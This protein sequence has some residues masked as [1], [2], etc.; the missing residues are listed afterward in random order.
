VLKP[1]R[2]LALAL[3]TGALLGAAAAPASAGSASDWIKTGRS[4]MPL[5]YYQGVTHD[6][7][8]NVYFDGV[9]TGLYRTDTKLR[10]EAQNVDVIDP[11]VKQSVGFNHIGDITWDKAEGGRIVLPLEC[12]DASKTPSNTCGIGGFGVADP[13]T[14]AWEYWVKL[15]PADIPKAMWAETSPDGRLIWTSSGQDLLA[16]NAADVSRADA[17]PASNDGPAIR[18]ARRVVGAVPAHGITGAVFVGPRLFLAGQDG[19]RFQVSSVDLTSGR[20]R[21]EIVETI[22]GESEGLDTFRGLG[23]SF[24]W[25]VMPFPQGANPPS[26]ERDKGS[27]L[28][29]KARPTALELVVTP[30]RAGAGRRTRFGFR[31]TDDNGDPVKGA[32]VKF[33]HER[34][35]T[36]ARGR[37]TIT[38]TLRAPGRYTAVAAKRGLKTARAVVR[39]SR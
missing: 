27:L 39:S 34:A 8:G 5:N 31:V 32:T 17:Q 11:G 7:R 9:F 12:Y 20:A 35:R 37:A 14:L 16:Y 15:D 36:D 6:N 30:R 1:N 13:K 29:Y 10:Q 18:P 4:T 28:N 19:D 3:A 22:S 25:M 2:I 21:P 23:G 24:H 26:F 38:A 33:S